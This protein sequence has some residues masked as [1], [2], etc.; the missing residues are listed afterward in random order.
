MHDQRALI[1]GRVRRLLAE[2]IRPAVRR[3]VGPLE[4]AAW[5]VPGPDPVPAAEGLTAAYE[6]IEVGD[7]WATEPW[8]TT[9]LRLRAQVPEQLRSERL[10]AVLDL[11][12][13]DGP[14]FGPEGLG[15]AA[16]GT[17]LKG[18]H[19]RSD[20][21]PV[22]LDA[23]GR[24]EAYVEAAANP[25]LAFF[26]PTRLGARPGSSSGQGPAQGQ[27]DG[28][29]M[30][31]PLRRAELVVVDETVRE[32]VADLVALEGLAA[33]LP[34]DT[35]R[36][37]QVL[38]ALSDAL[39]ALDLADVPGTA[40]AARA[41]LA[42]TLAAPAAASAHR[43]TA[44]G[45]A[46]IDTAWLWP[47]R[48]TRRKVS[49]TVAN[50]LALID[51]PAT[52]GDFVFALPAAQHCAWLE[53]DQ[54]QLFARLRA[55]VAAGRVVPVGGMWV[56]PDANLTGGESVCRQLT[57][58]A[59]LFRE[60]F[61]VQCEQLWLPDSFGYS[62]ALP[63]LAV[64]AGMRGLLTQKLSWNDTNRFPHHSFWWEGLD[65]TRIVAHFPSVDTYGSDLSGPQLAHAASNFADHGRADQSLVPFGYGDGG[66]GPTREMLAQ[67]ARVADLDGS[68]RVRLGSPTPF[69]AAV[70]AQLAAQSEPPVWVG[71]LALEKH[72]ATLTT[73]ARTKAGNRR[74]EALLHEAHLWAATAAV[75][76][77]LDY[78]YDEVEHCWEQVLV[79]QFHD[80]LPGSSI[81]W[82]HEQIESAHEQV[83]AELEGI[84]GAALD[85]LLG[86]SPEAALLGRSPE[87]AMPSG[88]SET[89]GQHPSA[90]GRAALVQAA[91]W[92]AEGLPMGASVPRQTAA[93]AP[94]AVS[95]V[96]IGHQAVLDNG[97]LRV[98]V[99]ARGLV[100]SLL[101]LRAD[102][103][104]IP[105]GAAAGLL[106]THQ[107]LPNAWDA[108][109]LERHHRGTARDLTE[110]ADVQLSSA[111][112]GTAV[113]A[114]HRRFGA[115]GS[116]SAVQTLELAPGA[117]ALRVDVQVDW[118]ERDTL[119]TLAWPVDVHTDQA[120]FE[121]QFGHVTR[122]THDNTSWDHARFEVPAHRWVHVGEPGYGVAIANERTYGWSVTRAARPGGGT[123]SIVRASLLRGAQF[124][125]PRA[126][127]GVH[128]FGFLVQ[129]GASVADA[130]RLG[131]AAALPPRRVPLPDPAPGADP[132]AAGFE[133][134]V[135]V[136]GPVVLETVKLADDRS[137]HVVL[138][139]YEPL[140]DQARAHLLPSFPVSAAVVTDLHETPMPPDDPQARAALQ[141]GA[142]GS[143]GSRLTV[144]LRPFQV[145][146][147]RLTPAG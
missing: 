102:R 107:D 131:Y 129:P 90:P 72:R 115:G 76:G 44:V 134:L 79:G 53:Q 110:L 30:L 67:A 37:W 126:D 57:L 117:R 25:E 81:T 29:G 8:A 54:P 61:G 35:H 42:P 14:G 80:I 3:V 95:A 65:G 16:D 113:L 45:H 34:S 33:T 122:H 9:W 137:G 49:R 121:T 70:E 32:L 123:V 140:G 128:R 38:H 98:V 94:A 83:A 146:T 144:R 82:V 66:G 24:F 92:L 48:E 11:G 4:V 147:V 18:L 43:I 77:L 5:A 139:L 62:A 86:R 91:P 138:R 6:S 100:V 120:R 63:Q 10:E 118:H 36:T 105:P 47:L 99:D 31:L 111:P 78:P 125:D 97:L 39:D 22:Q 58:G 69:F 103:E 135:R 60:R 21:L 13:G 88:S 136:V 71:E 19:P 40:A 132:A 112:D 68:P 101:D 130:I 26:T 73:Q 23:A 124:P 141:G 75:R 89:A 50:V 41:V 46:H 93:T 17:V 145:L 12:W 85:A 87:A 142:G 28:S 143:A 96:A 74:C 59:R 119:L 7:A 116:S 84:V 1:E 15:Y 109:D 56:E 64:L 108:W 27:A 133:P 2:R 52:S 104:L 114:I 20:W 106:Q 55:A 51:E 127:A